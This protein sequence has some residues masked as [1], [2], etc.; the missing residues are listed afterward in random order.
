MWLI[1]VVSFVAETLDVTIDSLNASGDGVARGGGL[2]LTIPFTIPGERVCV[3]VGA[4]RQNTAAARLLD[5]L[6]PSPHR[7]I[8]RWPHFG[9][10]AEAGVGPCGGCT[11]QHIEQLRLKTAFVERLVRTAA[12]TSPRVRPMLP[13]TPPDDPW[14]YRPRDLP[15]IARRR[16]TIQSIQPVDMFPHTAHVEAVVVLT[17]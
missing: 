12:P 4:R 10:G 17:R 1:V 14:G 5:V 15:S 16:Y 11:W 8:P 13:S 2:R 9:P 7:I 6:A 3:Q